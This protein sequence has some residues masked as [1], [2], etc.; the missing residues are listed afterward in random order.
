VIHHGLV[1]LEYLERGVGSLAIN[2]IVERVEPRQ[3][4]PAADFDFQP[5]DLRRIRQEHIGS[6]QI[7][8]LHKG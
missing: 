3:A 6:C 8:L 1:G 4:M 7:D 5:A 2:D